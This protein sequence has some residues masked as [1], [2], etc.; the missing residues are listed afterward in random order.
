MFRLFQ[1]SK[2]SINNA[3]ESASNAIEKARELSPVEFT[4]P[5]LSNFT[6]NTAILSGLLMQIPG[7]AADWGK[8]VCFTKNDVPYS[9][10]CSWFV[11]GFDLQ[12]QMINLL[13]TTCEIILV[14]REQCLYY[15]N[16]H[17]YFGS[18]AY[19]KSL[20][21]LGYPRIMQP[22]PCITQTLHNNTPTHKFGTVDD[23]KDTVVYGF[24]GVAGLTFFGVTTA[25]YIHN[26]NKQ[27]AASE[28]EIIN[29]ETDLN[30]RTPT[31]Q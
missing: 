29:D 5:S 9:F 14:D 31:M 24:L 26:K 3:I 28:Y 27:N 7:A 2:Q 21:D 11:N 6:N 22:D 30:P 25:C 18:S 1:Q 12:G 23:V 16:S 8:W 15:H 13:N 10:D 17:E 4:T 20:C 19:G